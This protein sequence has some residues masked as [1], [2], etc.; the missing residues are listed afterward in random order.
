MQTPFKPK[1]YNVLFRQ[2]IHCTKLGQQLAISLRVNPMEIPD[3]IMSLELLDM[4]L[5]EGQQSLKKQTGFCSVIMPFV[6]LDSNNPTEDI[7]EEEISIKKK[8]KDKD[9]DKRKD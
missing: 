5:P 2:F 6:I 1:K 9:K 8:D 4:S 3:V 7:A